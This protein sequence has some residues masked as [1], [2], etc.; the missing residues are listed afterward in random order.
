MHRLYDLIVTHEDWLMNRIL[1]HARL[2]GYTK[3][4]STLA[5][6]WRVSVQG[7][8]ES[9][10]QATRGNDGPPE[11]GP[12]D[13]FITDPI[14]SFGIVQAKRH[15]S[16]GVTLSM[17]IGLMKYYKQSYIDL[18]RQAGFD[19]PF[20][21]Q[22]RLFIERFFDRVEMGFT[23]EWSTLNED[24]KMKELQSSNRMMTN[25]KNKYLTL[26][27]STPTP[28][29]F[30][31]KD[32]MIDNMN[33]A[34]ATL[35]RGMETPGKT[36]YGEKMTQQP[37]PWKINE[38]TA[39]FSTDRMEHAFQ[40]ALETR[41][42]TRIFQIKL[43][44]MLDVSQKF[45]GIA[46]IMNDITESKQLEERLSAMSLTDDLTGLYNRRGFITLSCQQ[47]KVSDRTRK[48]MLLF[49]VDL[50]GLKWINDTLGHE[51]G[52]RALI[53][54][55]TLFRETFRTSDIIARL[56]GDEYAALSLDI[57]EKNPERFTARLHSLIEAQNNRENL[58]YRLSISVGHSYY[59]PENP[60]SIDELMSFADKMMYERKRKKK[61]LL[62]QETSLS[63]SNSSLQ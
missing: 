35:F 58:R 34:A 59:D 57:T 61:R 14:A 21:E 40:K 5:E 54:I 11:F 41:K 2:H 24:E 22:C 50:D 1:H 4:T 6:A 45:G 44:R 19:N 49:F 18:V 30:M 53:K 28:V 42:G 36:Y 37:L 25:E 46:L 13:S 60:C 62:L 39:F 33:H 23:V 3:Y 15:R 43:K 47:M 20:E 9:L 26:F 7:L 63:S 48:G 51:E 27:E 56:G 31:N 10:M 32:G 29:I 55:A 17:F 8:S 12:D 16:R 52:D 38:V